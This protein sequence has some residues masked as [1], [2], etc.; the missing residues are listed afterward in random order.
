MSD[1]ISQKASAQEMA[2]TVL[3]LSSPD[4]SV[5]NRSETVVRRRMSQVSLSEA[6]G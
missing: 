3:F 5:V 6:R 4:P 2:S 1:G